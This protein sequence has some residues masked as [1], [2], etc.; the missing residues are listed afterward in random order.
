MKF[1]LLAPWLLVLGMVI[2]AGWVAA[3]HAD[4]A[5]ATS[6][7]KAVGLSVGAAF[8]PAGELWI[9]GLDEQSRMFVQSTPDAGKTWSARRTLDARGD[10]ISRPR[11]GATARAGS[12]F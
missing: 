12:T 9:V 6:A 7:R 1:R 8:S 4:H 2:H 10:A 11:C 3:Q 5:R